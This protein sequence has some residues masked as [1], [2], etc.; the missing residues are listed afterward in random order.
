MRA[1][2]GESVKIVKNI[3]DHEFRIGET[4][5]VTAIYQEGTKYENYDGKSLERDAFWSF[6]MTEIAKV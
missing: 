1:K 3:S 4:V 2:V 6:G 5:L